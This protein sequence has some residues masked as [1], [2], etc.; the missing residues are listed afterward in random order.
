[1][2]GLA[3]SVLVPLRETG[4]TII[5]HH[6]AD[7]PASLQLEI[8]RRSKTLGITFERVVINNPN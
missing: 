7:S 8:E 1:M 5:V 3:L 4:E 2:L 6:F